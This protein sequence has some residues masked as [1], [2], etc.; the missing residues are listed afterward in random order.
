MAPWAVKRILLRFA[1]HLTLVNARAD[2]LFALAK[3]PHIMRIG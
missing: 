2:S 3:I 1:G